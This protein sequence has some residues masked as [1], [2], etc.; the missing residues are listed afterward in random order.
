MRENRP[1]G[2]EGGE[3]KSLPYPYHWCLP[4]G[5]LPLHIRRRGLF[6][7][8]GDRFVRRHHLLRLAAEPA[9]RN[10]VSLGL[11]L[12]DHEQ[13]RDFR[14]RVLADLVID[15]LVA[16]IDLDAQARAPCRGSDHLGVLI[17]LRGDGGD[18]GLDRRQPEWK[19]AGI[20][21]DQDADETFHRAADRAM[22][23]DRHLLRTVGIDIE[24]TEAF[25][26]IEIDLRGAA[27]PVAANG[28]A[29]HIFEFRA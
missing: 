19:I 4:C 28:I 11:L 29:Q 21:F 10:R 8:R 24:R 22:Y 25:R 26:Q 3:A 6:D 7:Q 16:Q 17:T 20:M 23:H 9:D 2:S 13:C 5:V 15:L 14:Q 27:L 1:Y 18:D 12:A